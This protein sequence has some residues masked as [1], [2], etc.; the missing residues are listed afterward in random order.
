ML[1]AIWALLTQKRHTYSR[2]DGVRIIVYRE[3]YDTFTGYVV[4]GNNYLTKSGSWEML[5]NH[6]L[7]GVPTV[8][9]DMRCNPG[10]LVP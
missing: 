3:T 1:Q 5:K 6:K 2:G 9:I 7:N 10:Q 4:L 8:E